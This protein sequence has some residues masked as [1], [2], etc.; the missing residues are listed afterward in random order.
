MKD[1][2]HDNKAQAAYIASPIKTQGAYSLVESYSIPYYN[3]IGY[4]KTETGM[5]D[6]KCTLHP[7]R[8][9]LFLPMDK[10]IVIY[11]KK[12]FWGIIIEFLKKER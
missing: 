8:Q 5:P 11:R 4:I 6:F 7:K 12:S 3:L 2:P 10:K 9:Y 1:L